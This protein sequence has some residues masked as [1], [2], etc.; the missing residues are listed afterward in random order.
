TNNQILFSINSLL[1]SLSL[2]NRS[3]CFIDNVLMATKTPTC[4]HRFRVASAEQSR[5]AGIHQG[6][7]KLKTNYLLRIYQ[8]YKGDFKM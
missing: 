3:L 7:I 1:F 4:L 6:R 8:I 5:Q 2:Y